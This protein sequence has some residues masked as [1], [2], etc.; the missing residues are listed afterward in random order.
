MKSL[1]LKVSFTECLAAAKEEGA[2]VKNGYSQDGR[3]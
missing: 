2:T 3:S 1:W